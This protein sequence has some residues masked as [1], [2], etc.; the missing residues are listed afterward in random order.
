MKHKYNLTGDI[1]EGHFKD[2]MRHGYGVLKSKGG[3]ICYGRWKKNKLIQNNRT[4]N[5]SVSLEN[6]NNY[7]D[8]AS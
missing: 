4:S 2:N 5:S 6:G 3:R 8:I 1:Y 7:K